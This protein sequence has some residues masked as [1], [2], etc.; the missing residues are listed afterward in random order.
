MSSKGPEPE[1]VLILYRAEVSTEHSL[2]VWQN[3]FR[4][5]SRDHSSRVAYCVFQNGA[6]GQDP[7]KLLENTPRL[8]LSAALITLTA[9]KRKTAKK[10]FGSKIMVQVQPFFV[11]PEFSLRSNQFSFCILTKM[12]KDKLKSRAPIVA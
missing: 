12:Y 6:T 8:A 10:T 7:D 2:Q 11:V 9:G 5:W 3:G 1:R 4:M